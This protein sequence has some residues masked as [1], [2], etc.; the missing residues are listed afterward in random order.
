M[1]VNHSAVNIVS[2]VVVIVLSGCTLAF[3]NGAGSFGEI[4]LS[5]YG[6]TVTAPVVVKDLPASTT[7]KSAKTAKVIDDKR[8]A[9]AIFA[10]A[11]EAENK[12]REF[13][14]E[15]MKEYTFAATP[16]Q[17][18]TST[19]DTTISHDLSFR[20]NDANHDLR[21]CG[22][23]AKSVSTGYYAFAHGFGPSDANYG[24]AVCNSKR[25]IAFSDDGH[26]PKDCDKT[27][28]AKLFGYKDGSANLFGFKV[29]PSK[30]IKDTCEFQRHAW[31]SIIG[32][33]VLVIIGYSGFVASMERYAVNDTTRSMFAIQS[34]FLWALFVV[35]AGLLTNSYVKMY[36]DRFLQDTSVYKVTSDLAPAQFPA[37]AS[38]YDET[39]ALCYGATTAIVAPDK[40]VGPLTLAAQTTHCASWEHFK[41]A[42]SNLG[43]TSAGNCKHGDKLKDFYVAKHVCEHPEKFDRVTDVEGVNLRYSDRRSTRPSDQSTSGIPIFEFDTDGSTG[44]IVIWIF[45]W[46]LVVKQTVVSFGLLVENPCLGLCSDPNIAGG[47]YAGAFH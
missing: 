6:T 2:W 42:M 16:V 34:F 9:N 47:S 46:A 30:W 39:F 19:G 35:I 18:K 8:K 29:G 45:W 22:D 36:D 5:V 21:Y 37:R 1:N 7:A 28:L 14:T 27:Y 15:R 17:W 10:T 43:L 13:L 41:K 4:D 40:I 25:A 31:G 12:F 11:A 24:T 23:D 26:R 32:L 20:F 3:I 33:V 38:M 44:L